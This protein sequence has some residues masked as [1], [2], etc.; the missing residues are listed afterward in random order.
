MLFALS[1]AVSALTLPSISPG[2]WMVTSATDSSPPPGGSSSDPVPIINIDAT[3]RNDTFIVRVSTLATPLVLVRTAT[4]TKFGR[5]DDP[6]TI[7]FSEVNGRPSA[8]GNWNG[9][10]YRFV[11]LG[12]STAG[13]TL[14]KDDRILSYTFAPRV[15]AQ[16]STVKEYGPYAFFAVMFLAAQWYLTMA[17]SAPDEKKAK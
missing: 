12:D 3:E 2:V 14:V 16:R 10:F 17:K 5:P 7:E 15:V 4:V 13:L 1:F 8:S 11:V 6:T 9:Y